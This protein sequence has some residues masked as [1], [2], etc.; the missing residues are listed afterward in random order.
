MQAQSNNPTRI[1]F[2]ATSGAGV[3]Q[4]LPPI[5]FASPLAETDF[6]AQQGFFYNCTCQD[7]TLHNADSKNPRSID[8]YVRE[9]D[10]LAVRCNKGGRLR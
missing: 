10:I 1:G 5:S 3:D 4:Q 9:R 8:R 7:T 2:P 6:T